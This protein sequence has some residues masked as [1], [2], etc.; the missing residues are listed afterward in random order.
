MLVLGGIQKSPGLF[1]A[2]GEETQGF[3]PFPLRTR[4][5]RPRYLQWEGPSHCRLDKSAIMTGY[6]SHWWWWFPWRWCWWFSWLLMLIVSWLMVVW[7][8]FR[9]LW[10]FL[11]DFRALA[12]HDERSLGE[13]QRST[14]DDMSFF[15]SAKRSKTKHAVINYKPWRVKE[16]A[17]L[18]WIKVRGHDKWQDTLYENT[19]SI[20]I[21]SQMRYFDV[22]VWW[23]ILSFCDTERHKA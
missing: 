2:I 12:T 14:F 11:P 1:G 4:G 23:I 18:T 19:S 5:W 10:Y 15:G 13:P 21:S 3:K 22:I 9:W 17:N 7:R 6:K 8:I 20:S 16:H